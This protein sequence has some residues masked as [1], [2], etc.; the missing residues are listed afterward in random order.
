MKVI[1]KNGNVLLEKEMQAVRKA[2][3]SS[4]WVLNHT[5][6]VKKTVTP[7]VMSK[8][9]FFKTVIPHTNGNV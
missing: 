9:E 3:V 8:E 7:K 1:D 6:G 2:K 5:K 4:L